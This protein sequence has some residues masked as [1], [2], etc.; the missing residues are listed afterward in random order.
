[1]QNNQIRQLSKAPYQAV[2][3]IALN[4]SRTGCYANF[5]NVKSHSCKYMFSISHLYSQPPIIS[6]SGSSQNAA[7]DHKKV[8]IK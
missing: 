1:M 8:Y 5:G 6:F 3:W 2:L 4:N 7:E